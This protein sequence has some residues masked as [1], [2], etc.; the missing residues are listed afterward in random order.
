MKRL[1]ITYSNAT[2]PEV[3]NT[4]MMPI[5]EL[6]N[7]MCRVTMTEECFEDLLTILDAKNI[8]YNV[9]Q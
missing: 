6:P 1:T 2:Y 5:E 8:T 4:I 3:N 9:E 7:R